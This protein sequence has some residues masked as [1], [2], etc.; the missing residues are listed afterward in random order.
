MDTGLA[1]WDYIKAVR[2]DIV[3]FTYQWSYQSDRT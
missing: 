1:D 3:A 2:Y